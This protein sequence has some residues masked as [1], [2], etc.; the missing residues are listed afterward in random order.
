MAKQKDK[1]A[2]PTNLE[3]LTRSIDKELGSG[4]IMRGRGAVVNVDVFPTN[5]AAFDLAL[6]VAGIPQGRIIELYGTESSGKTT[7]CLEIIAACQKHYFASKKRNGVA[8]FIDAEHALDPVWAEKLGVNMDELLLSQPDSGEDSFTIA[9]KLAESG[10]VD[11]IVIDSVAA[12]TPRVILEGEMGDQTMA[13]LARLMSTG[14]S[15]IKGKCNKTKTSIIFINQIREK[16][17]VMFGNPESTPG[18]RA[19][20]FYASVRIEVRKG[21]PI[22]SDDTVI[23]FRPTIKIVKNKVAPPFTTAEYDI[24]V[25]LDPRPTN[26]IDKIAS[27]LETAEELGVIKKNKNFLIYNEKNIGNGLNNAIK[28]VSADESLYQTI[29]E[30]TYGKM[31]EK[32][33]ENIIEEEIE[34]EDEEIEDE[35]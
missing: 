18:G 8:A 12:L 3:E 5:I 31:C 23:G 13:A 22:K 35:D 29:R 9:E 15:K 25:G 16:V 7:T 11:L 17:G 32:I 34:V 30:I 19:L 28:T 4:T 26:G 1:K 27:L 14:M 6:G 21:K 24:C 20:K 33:P 2:A 10:L